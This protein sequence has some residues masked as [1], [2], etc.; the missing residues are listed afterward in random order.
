[1]KSLTGSKAGSLALVLAL[2]QPRDKAMLDRLVWWKS[3]H[4]MY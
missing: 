2:C 4:L 1:M 3:I